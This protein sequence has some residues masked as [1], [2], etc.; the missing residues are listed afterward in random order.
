MVFVLGSWDSDAK[1]HGISLVIRVSFI[2]PK[3]PLLT[4]SEFP[5]MR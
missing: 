5:L 2:I 4:I 3:E 1:T